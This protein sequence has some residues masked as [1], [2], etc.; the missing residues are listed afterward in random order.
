MA[1]WIRKTTAP[2]VTANARKRQKP[3][4]DSLPS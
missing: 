2:M 3:P 1:S 4:L